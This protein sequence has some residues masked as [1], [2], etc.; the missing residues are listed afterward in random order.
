[1]DYFRCVIVQRLSHVLEFSAMEP[2]YISEF[3]DLYDELAGQLESCLF[4]FDVSEIHL[5]CKCEGCRNEK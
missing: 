5:L 4:V 1:M 2:L 3:P